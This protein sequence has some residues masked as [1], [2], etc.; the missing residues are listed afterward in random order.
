MNT[1]YYV[2]K[3]GVSYEAP[4]G[5]LTDLASI[6]TLASG[7]FS[8]VDHRAPGVI[9]DARYMLSRVTGEKRAD[10][11]SL[12]AEMSVLQG[13][14]EAQ[15]FALQSGLEIGGWHAWDECQQAGVT[16]AD[17]DISVLSD[18]EIADYK[19]RFNIADIQLSRLA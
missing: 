3:N 19:V 18:E 16:W 15:R 14:N 7:L 13:A 6:P 1:I 5:M 9:H 2:D 17:F 4:R 12:F 10:L 11:D 8:N